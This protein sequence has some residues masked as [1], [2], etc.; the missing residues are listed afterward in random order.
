M[1]PCPHGAKCRN[2]LQKGVCTGW[3]DKVQYKE[4]MAEF[5]KNHPDGV[6]AEPGAKKPKG[7]GK[8]K[9]TDEQPEEVKVIRPKAKG[10]KQPGISA[11][12]LMRITLFTKKCV[13]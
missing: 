13:V 2:I 12:R 4:L 3:H 10:K 7:G 1:K 9:D 5:R 8:G 11:E 6:P